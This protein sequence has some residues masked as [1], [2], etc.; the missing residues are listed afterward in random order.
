N[1]KQHLNFILGRHRR[2]E[3]ENVEILLICGYPR[4]KMNPSTLLTGFS[5]INLLQIEYG[6]LTEFQGNFPQMNN[7]ET[8]NITWTNLSELKPSI[9]SKVVNL[10]Y[11]DLRYNSLNLFERPLELSKTFQKMHLL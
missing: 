8:V 11:L 1:N 5:R 7:L 6:N 2:A 9:F 3:L 10:K 4:R